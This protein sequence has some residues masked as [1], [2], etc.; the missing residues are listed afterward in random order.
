MAVSAYVF[1]EV[2]HGKA[3]TVGEAIRKLPFVKKTNLITGPYDVISLIEAPEL[4]SLGEDVV[5]KIQAI[6]G[7]VRSLTNIIMD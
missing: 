6:P 3:R 1:I 2:E 5:S 7:V 4:A